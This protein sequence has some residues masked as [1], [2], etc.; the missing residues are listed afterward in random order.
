[1]GM[2]VLWLKFQVGKTAVYKLVQWLA[3]DYTGYG[4]AS[5]KKL[6]AYVHFNLVIF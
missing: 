4:A 2:V 6:L 3:D 1:M 5:I